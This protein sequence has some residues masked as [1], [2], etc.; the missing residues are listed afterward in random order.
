VTTWVVLAT[1]ESMSQAVASSVRGR[2]SV[3]AVSNAYSLAP[4]ADALAS[5]DATWW[6]ANPAARQFSGQKFS[7]QRVPGLARF[8][9][10][11]RSDTNS[12]LLGLDVARHLGATRVV[13]LGFDMRGTH[14]FGRHPAPLKN[15]PEHR[16][17]V[18]K[19]QFALWGRT[20]P[21]VEVINC[22][23]ASKLDCFPR[24][25]LEEVLC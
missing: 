12:G 13:L 10:S 2:C 25:V 21:K 19:R 3:V 22:T 8:V 23:P 20:H 5:N 9:G 18:F 6:E 24:G 15:T 17:E 1:G 7:A 14:Y 11:V 4:W 16:F